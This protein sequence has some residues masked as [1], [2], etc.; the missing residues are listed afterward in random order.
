V[1]ATWAQAGSPHPHR[2]VPIDS[3]WLTPWPQLGFATSVA[4]KDISSHHR[5]CASDSAL[6]KGGIGL[7]A[8]DPDDDVGFGTLN[9]SDVWGGAGS[10]VATLDGGGPASNGGGGGTPAHAS[11]VEG[12]DKRASSTVIQ[13][14]SMEIG[15]V[16]TRV[17]STF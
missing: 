7:D 14:T 13:L 9:P 5:L 17:E 11:L 16:V 8:R 10:G 6:S 1:R 2:L 12:L 15:P 3:S 4:C